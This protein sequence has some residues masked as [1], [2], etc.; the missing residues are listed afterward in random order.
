MLFVR[1]PMGRLFGVVG[2]GVLRLLCAYYLIKKYIQLY[3][4]VSCQVPQVTSASMYG[5]A[6][7][8]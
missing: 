4:G 2:P 1:I 7:I 5:T 6:K 8:I 3:S